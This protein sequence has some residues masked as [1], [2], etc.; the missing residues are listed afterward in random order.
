M[1]IRPVAIACLALLGGCA[2][3]GAQW[4]TRGGTQSP[5]GRLLRSIQVTSDFDGFVTGRGEVGGFCLTRWRLSGDT[6]SI[7]RADEASTPETVACQ[8]H[9][10]FLVRPVCALTVKEALFYPT[11]APIVVIRCPYGAAG[12][13]TGFSKLMREG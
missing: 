8:G 1:G 2:S 12:W 5:P 13:V 3:L 11:A 9:P 6:L 4:I 10:V 7:A